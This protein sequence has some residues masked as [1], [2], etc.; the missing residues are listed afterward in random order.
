MDELDVGLRISLRGPE[1]QATLE[2]FQRQLDEWELAMPPAPPLVL[3]FG[4]GDFDRVGLIEYWIANEADA[5]YCGKLLYVH[6]GQTCPLHSHR[7]K[8]ETFF[9]VKGRVRMQFDGAEREMRP[10]DVLPVPLG[11]VH[12]FTGVGPALLL[13]V[14]TPC[15]VD[16][17]YFADARIPIGGNY[18]QHGA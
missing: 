3:D 4:L 15:R 9:V 13:E 12:A 17:N 14:S 8:M 16:D 1:A 11:K 2:R 10:G 7:E 5:G 6:D 18:R